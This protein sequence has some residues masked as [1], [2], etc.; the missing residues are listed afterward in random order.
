MAA[1]E[2]QTRLQIGHVLFVDI[3]FPHLYAGNGKRRI[4]LAASNAWMDFGDAGRGH[5]K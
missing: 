1:A 4:N 3:Q 5:K 2:K